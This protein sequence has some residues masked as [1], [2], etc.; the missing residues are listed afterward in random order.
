MM[1]LIEEG[2]CVCERE[3]LKGVCV[4]RLGT[5]LFVELP[6]YDPFPLHSG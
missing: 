4:L 2:V 3:R 6:S 5:C 1:S